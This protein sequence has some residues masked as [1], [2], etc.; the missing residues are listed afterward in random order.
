MADESTTEDLK[1]AF[2]A[3]R[4][5]GDHGRLEAIGR[6]LYPEPAVEDRIAPARPA[7]PPGLAPGPLSSPRDV[8]ARINVELEQ[9]QGHTLESRRQALLALRDQ[10]YQQDFEE[11]ARAAEAAARAEQ[12]SPRDQGGPAILDVGEAPEG[13]AWNTPVVGL[14]AEDLVDRHVMSED[15]FKQW[16]RRGAALYTAR[17]AGGGPASPIRL[18][19]AQHGDL[20]LVVPDLMRR[21]SLVEFIEETG[22]AGEADFDEALAREA[23]VRRQERER[24]R[25]LGDK[26]ATMNQGSKEYA[27][28]AEQRNA[29][30]KRFYEGRRE[31]PR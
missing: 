26:L 29:H 18:D 11:S 5:A 2:D 21:R 4:L 23:E 31:E 13:R 24:G 16:A 28:L 15:A 10:A 12:A 14:L 17:Q 22:L 19:A 20:E 8:I 6:Q 1:A 9:G 30:Y 25:A 7:P 27:A 3:A